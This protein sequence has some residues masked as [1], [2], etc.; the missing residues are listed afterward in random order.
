MKCQKKYLTKKGYD[1]KYGVRNLRREIQNCFENPISE[2]L[3]KN[4]Y[5]EG[6]TIIIK[7]ERD[8]LIFDSRP[9]K[10]SQSKIAKK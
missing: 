10:K 7:S 9:P 1:P 8:K 3:L 6:S 4:I 5:T 2:M